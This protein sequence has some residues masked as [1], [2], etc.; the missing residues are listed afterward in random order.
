MWN[1]GKLRKKLS[2]KSKIAEN[3]VQQDRTSCCA[4]CFPSQGGKLRLLF[5]GFFSDANIAADFA[6]VS[7]ARTN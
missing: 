1:T 3:Q 4:E 6:Y 7:Q 2:E 5:L